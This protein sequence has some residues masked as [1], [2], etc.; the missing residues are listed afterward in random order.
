MSLPTD[1]QII[2]ADLDAKINSGEYNQHARDVFKAIQ[3]CIITNKPIGP[4]LQAQYV[5]IIANDQRQDRYT[6]VARTS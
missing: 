1:L 3:D 4:D 2:V 6:T 5:Q